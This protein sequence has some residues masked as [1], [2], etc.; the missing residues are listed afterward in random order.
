MR[1]KPG[2]EIEG[3]H[4][5]KRE[6]YARLTG[7]PFPCARLLDET[8]W[9]KNWRKPRYYAS[10]GRKALA[11]LGAGI[12]AVIVLIVQFGLFRRGPY[13]PEQLVFFDW[14]KSAFWAFVGG[15]AS[16]WAITLISGWL[17][18]GEDYLLKPSMGVEQILG[19]C[20]RPVPYILFGHDHVR[21]AQRL[22]GGNWYIN[23]GAWLHKYAIERKRLLREPLE[24]SFARMIDTHSVLARQTAGGPRR[25]RVELLRWNDHA[26]RVEPCETFRAAD[27]FRQRP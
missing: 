7:L 5:Q 2:P 15:G 13:R 1:H 27:E 14:I 24:Y 21:N 18:L 22:P 19:D 6:A 26:G 9:V 25:P 17:N 20:D 11:L 8:P 4:H 23:T 10:V 12:V 3:R 16:Y